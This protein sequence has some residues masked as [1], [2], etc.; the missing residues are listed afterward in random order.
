M[1]KTYLIRD[2]AFLDH[3]GT[4]KV[5]GE[6]IELDSDVALQHAGRLSEISAPT[7]AVPLPDAASAPNVD[8]YR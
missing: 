4:T 3:D 5:A 8:R 1:K 2:G 7:K 6:T